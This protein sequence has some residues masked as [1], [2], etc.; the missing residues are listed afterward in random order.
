MSNFNIDINNFLNLENFSH[1]KFLIF[2]E[3]P[4]LIVKAK[5]HALADE[6]LRMVEKVYLDME[7]RDLKKILIRQY[8]LIAFLMKKGYFY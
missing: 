6:D 3:E 8:Y 2:G 1:K 4:A 7:E 5:N